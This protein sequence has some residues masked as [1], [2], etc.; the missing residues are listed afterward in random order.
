MSKNKI[1]DASVETEEGSEVREV[2][3]GDS[4][5]KLDDAGNLLGAEAFG[6]VIEMI[7]GGVKVTRPDGSA[8]VMNEQGDI[9]FENLVPKSVGVKSLADVVSHTIRADGQLRIHRIEFTNGG[10]VEVTYTPEGNFVRSAGFNIS[11]SISKDSEILYGPG[12]P[13]PTAVH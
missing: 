8:I 5:V 1:D 9:S 4:T 10:H 13:A 7:G 11:Q 12:E 3:V 2:T 6:N